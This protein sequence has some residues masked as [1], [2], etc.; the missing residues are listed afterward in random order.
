M[1][2]SIQSVENI[3]EGFGCRSHQE[4]ARFLEISR[5]SLN[6]VMDAYRSAQLK[7][8]VSTAEKATIS[9]LARRLYPALSR[10]MAYL[11]ENP[12]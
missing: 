12:N 1:T 11:R 9:K 7:N 6:E 8:Y 3:S 10:L 4:F 5:R 2:P